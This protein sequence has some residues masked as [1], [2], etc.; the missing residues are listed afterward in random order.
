MSW[1]SIDISSL[2]TLLGVPATGGH[3][4]TKR[5]RRRER[6]EESMSVKR[7]KKKSLTKKRK[8]ITPTL[9]SKCYV[10]SLTGI[11]T[12]S[13][14]SAMPEVSKS[15]VRCA[16]ILKQKEKTSSARSQDK[17]LGLKYDSEKPP[18]AYIPKAALWAEG[19]AFKYG[20]KK[21]DSWN[22]K[23]G[24]ALSRSLSAALRHILQFLD[25][26]NDDRESGVS[27]LG[28]ARANLGMALDTLEN[29]PEMDDRY[30]E[31]KKS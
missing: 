10:D 27:H 5:S 24:L 22:Y 20:A 29:H 2:R 17:N 14:C 16:T 21:Y 9:W 7:A 23:N 25:G 11:Y 19:E 12:H 30:K 31:G 6:V 26:E 18:L 3:G 28:C 4:E 8:W 1:K 13:A 15:S